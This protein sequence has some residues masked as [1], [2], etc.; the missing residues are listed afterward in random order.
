M[1]VG[2]RTVLSI[3][4]A[5]TKKKG[6]CAPRRLIVT[7]E[8]LALEWRVDHR[9]DG[10]FADGKNTVGKSNVGVESL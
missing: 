5:R 2:A 1:V 8:N 10:P 6:S 3:R 9:V 4:C 7:R